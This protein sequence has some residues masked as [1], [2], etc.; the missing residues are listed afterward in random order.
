MKTTYPQIGRLVFFLA[1]LLI[2]LPVSK[3]G[4]QTQSYTDIKTWTSDPHFI[5]S[6]AHPFYGNLV[7]RTITI[8]AATGWTPGNYIVSGYNGPTATGGAD[9]TQNMIVL[10]A[11]PAASSGA[12]TGGQGSAVLTYATAGAAVTNGDNTYVA[13][14]TEPPPTG[15]GPFTYRWYRSLTSGFTA[16]S[17]T[18]VSTNIAP[19]LGLSDQQTY[20]FKCIATDSTAATQTSNQIAAALLIAPL[21]VGFIGDSITAGFGQTTS[22]V[23]IFASQI[24]SQYG[25]RMVTAVNRGYG[26]AETNDWQP[27][28]SS[29]YYSAATSGFGSPTACPYVM[30]MLGTNDAS[31]NGL[32]QTHVSATQYQTQLLGIVNPLV[33]AGY[34]V[35]LNAPPYLQPYTYGPNQWDEAS[36]DLIKQYIAVMDGVCNGTTIL[37]GDRLAYQYFA[38]HQLEINDGT[39]PTQQGYYSLGYFWAKAYAANTGLILGGTKRRT[40]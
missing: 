30:V 36:L 2:L 8:T 37:K 26:G 14:A 4:A 38:T 16:T 23:Q 27:G 40:Q 32:T 17:G 20:Y 35:I 13:L 11:Y 29:G 10:Y 39:H 9:G 18:S 5:Y 25:P 31:A 22:A 6:V 33:T 19:A 7:G 3:A 34:K 21:K 15:T 24:Q 12:T 28:G 1:A